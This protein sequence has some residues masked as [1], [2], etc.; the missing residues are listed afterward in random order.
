MSEHKDLN[1]GRELTDEELMA[2]TG[3]ETYITNPVDATGTVILLYGIWPT[4]KYGIVPYY[5]VKPLYGI[6]PVPEYGVLPMYG[7]I[8]QP[9]Y[10][11]IASTE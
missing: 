10:G 8:P 3:G 7:I 11:I 2:M 9:L 1:I 4:L 5:G 6:E